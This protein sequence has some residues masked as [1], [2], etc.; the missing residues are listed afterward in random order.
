[1]ILHDFW[2]WLGTFLIVAAAA[3]GLGSTLRG[4]RRCHRCRGPVPHAERGDP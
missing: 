3:E 1:V 4:R 2:S